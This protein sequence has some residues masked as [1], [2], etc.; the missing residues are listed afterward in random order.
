LALIRQI[1][2]QLA[3]R[4]DTAIVYGPTPPHTPQFFAPERVTKSL[5]PLDARSPCS[6]PGEELRHAA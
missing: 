2:S 1:L 5:D 4:G 3:D 6:S